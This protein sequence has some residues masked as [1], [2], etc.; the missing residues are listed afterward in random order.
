MKKGFVGFTFAFLALTF[1]ASAGWSWGGYDNGYGNGNAYGYGGNT[2][3]RRTSDVGRA[4]HHLVNEVKEAVGLRPGNDWRHRGYR[5]QGNFYR[6]PTYVIQSRP[7]VVPVRQVRPVRRFQHD[8]C[9]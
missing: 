5:P 2:Y 3:H 1:C 9:W 6:Q 4:F 8:N 7:V